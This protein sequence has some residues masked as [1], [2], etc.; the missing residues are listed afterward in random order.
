MQRLRTEP[1]EEPGVSRKSR[2]G[3]QRETDLQDV[4]SNEISRRAHDAT[5]PKHIRKMYVQEEK[6]RRR[7]NRQK[8]MNPP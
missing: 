7:R 1:K 2:K 5:L 6:C 4:S 8:R 3:N